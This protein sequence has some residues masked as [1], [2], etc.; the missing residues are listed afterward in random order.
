MY[1][2]HYITIHKINMLYK[3]FLLL[4]ML[5]CYAIP[6]YYVYYHYNCNNSVS[7]IICNEDY[8]NVILFFMM[9]M[10]GELYYMKSK[11]MII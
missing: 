10:G 6:I 2:L 7:N 4:F 1:V 11:G 5:I 8:K 3:N 9:L